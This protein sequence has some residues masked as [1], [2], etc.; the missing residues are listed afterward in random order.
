MNSIPKRIISLSVIFA[1]T[2]CAE[3]W[4]KPGASEAD[5]EAMKAECNSQSAAKFPP[6][7]RQVPVTNGYV[8][9]ATTSCSD[10][11]HS[12]DCYTL[13]GQYVPPALIAIDDNENARNQNIRACFFKN[14]WLPVAADTHDPQ[15]SP[16]P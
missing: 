8:T 6:L 2:G 16:T 15:Y 5:F 11:G 4:H 3:Q 9:P 10:T 1:L 7:I 13:G 12:V 14:G